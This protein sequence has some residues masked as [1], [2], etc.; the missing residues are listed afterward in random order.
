MQE[1]RAMLVLNR[2]KTTS[3]ESFLVN[4]RKLQQDYTL[5]LKKLQQSPLSDNNQI[6]AQQRISNLNTL[7]EI[8]KKGIELISEDLALANRYQDALTV[9]SQQLELWKSKNQMHQQLEKL[10]AQEDRLRE[11]LE[12]LYENSIKL[13]QQA[14]SG[15]DTVPNYTLEAR[16]LLNNQVINLTQYKIA[17]IDLQKKL[18]KADYKLE[19]SPDIRTLQAVTETYKNAITQLVEMEE[20]LKK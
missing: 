14:Q 2:A 12:K 16:L 15:M 17:E 8:N 4:Q 3:L 6:S 11:S 5:R 18:V 1:N 10:R 9:Q 7:L 19:K 20:S 13:Q